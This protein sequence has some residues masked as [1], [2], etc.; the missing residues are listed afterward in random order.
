[1]L[2]ISEFLYRR[3]DVSLDNR[4]WLPYLDGGKYMSKFVSELQKAAE[5]IHINSKNLILTNPV[6]RGDL[7]SMTRGLL[8]L[9]AAEEQLTGSIS[10]GSMDILR[11]QTELI[12]DAFQLATDGE[13]EGFAALLLRM[14]AY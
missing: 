11:K 1:M 7:L 5:R 8:D 13:A 14:S 9:L 6:E 4:P 2:H 12:F 3:A 10:D